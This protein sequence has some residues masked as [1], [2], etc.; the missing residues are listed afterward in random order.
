[1]EMF[2]HWMQYH[3]DE[4]KRPSFKFKVLESFKDC[5]SR[6]VAEAIW[7]HYAGDELLNSKNEYN[8]N[9]LSRVVVDEDDFT[10]KKKLRQEEL[11]ELEDRKHLEEFKRAKRKP[12]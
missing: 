12:V 5:P 1:M 8:S 11:K 2:K 6:Q 9:H 3:G 4:D 10:K 7:I